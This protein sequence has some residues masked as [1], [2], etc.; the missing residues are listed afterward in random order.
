MNDTAGRTKAGEARGGGSGGIRGGSGGPSGG[1]RRDGQSGRGSAGSGAAARR[2]L[3]A[4][5]RVEAVK[6]SVRREGDSLPLLP[7]LVLQCTE[8]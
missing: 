5:D 7:F 8:A 3:E 4:E 2:G 1:A 6:G